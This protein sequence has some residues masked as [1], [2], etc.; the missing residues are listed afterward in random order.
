MDTHE[1]I[2][3]ILDNLAQQ[4]DELIVKAHLA[5]LEA[6]DEWKNVES[7]LSQLRAKTGP[8]TDTAK[9]AAKDIQTAAKQLADEI[10][11]GYDKIRKLF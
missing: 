4:R 1:E 2:Q 9:E 11:R 3:K 8:L 5:K 6:M 7:K 10:S